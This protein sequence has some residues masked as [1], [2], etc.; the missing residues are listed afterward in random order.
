MHYLEHGTDL[1]TA[2]LDVLHFSPAESQ[3]QVFKTLSNLNYKTADYLR[4]DED[5]QL[6]L[7]DLD[8]PDDSWD[9][10][11]VYHILEHIPDDTKAMAEMYRV[12]RPGGRAF[13]QVPIEIGRNE[14]YEDFSIDTDKG[15]A[16]AFGQKDHV[17]KYGSEGFRERLEA[18]GFDVDAVDHIAHLDSEVVARHRL[19]ADFRTPLDERIWVLTKPKNAKRKKKKKKKPA[20]PSVDAGKAGG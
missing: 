20:R 4:T 13:V 9:A 6:D 14:T 18:A 12:L 19:S 1:W 8:Q 11:I 3:K 17:R 5:L 16:R 10:L 15:R 2:E 7:T